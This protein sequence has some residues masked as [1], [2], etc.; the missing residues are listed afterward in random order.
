MVTCKNCSTEFEGKHCPVCGQRA[1]VKRITNQYVMEEVRDRVLRYDQGFLFTV[2]Q[3]L[4]RPGH[5]IREYIEGKRV[6]YTKPIKFM[7]WATALNFLIFH[8]LGLDEDMVQ[9]I[10]TDGASSGAQA[11][12]VKFTQY[13]FDHPAIIMLLMIPNIALFSWLYFRKRGYNYAEHFVL[14]TYL[15]GEVSLLG[16][17][18]NPM[19]KF[20]GGTQDNLHLKITLASLVWLVYV[21]WAYVGF[22]RPER[23]KWLYWL[24]AVLAVL[25]GYVAMLLLVSVLTALLVIAFW[26]MLKSHFG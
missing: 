1:K 16:L 14:N 20:F 3:L 8:F 26:P 17:L 9:A 6:A 11:F 4:R 21:G 18:T 10:K 5:A 15:M 23:R 22:F 19:I 13:L 12:Q 25:S 7:I 2:L 24:K